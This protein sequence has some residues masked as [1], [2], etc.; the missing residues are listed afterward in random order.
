[1]VNLRTINLTEETSYGQGLCISS[2]ESGPPPP[3]ASLQVFIEE[4]KFLL[5][6]FFAG[7]GES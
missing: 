4:E 5:L 3:H 2:M 7:E 6:L 1:M